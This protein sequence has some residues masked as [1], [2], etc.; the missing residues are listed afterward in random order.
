MMEMPHSVAI[1]H[2]FPLHLA[3]RHHAAR[4]PVR[5]YRHHTPHTSLHP[6]ISIIAKLL[7][8]RLLRRQ[9]PNPADPGA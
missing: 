2:A 7:R 3:W 9:N 1:Q 4:T 8:Q 5:P 6:S